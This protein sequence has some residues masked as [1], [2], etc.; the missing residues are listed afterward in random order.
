MKIM[1]E[2]AKVQAE[3]LKESAV[4]QAKIQAESE[5]REVISFFT[6]SLT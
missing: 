1:I 2:Q 6:F 5:K 3:A 4:A